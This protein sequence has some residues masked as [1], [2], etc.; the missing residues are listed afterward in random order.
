[1]PRPATGQV[2]ERDGKRGTTFA[3]RFR[4]HGERQYVTLG[5]S[6]DGWTRARADTELANTLADVRRGIWQPP[7]PAPIPDAPKDPTFHEFA[8]EWLAAKRPEVK[9]ETASHYE[10]ELTLHLLPF[11]HRHTLSQITVQEVD[12]YRQSM[13]RRG[14]LGATSINKTITRLGQILEVAVEYDLI[15]RNP[16]KG[17]RRRLKA[18]RNTRSHIDRADH[19]TALLAAAGALDAAARADRRH[20]ARRAIVATLVFGGLRIS[21][22]CALRWRDVDLAAG[23]IRV[24]EAKTEAGIRTVDVLPVLRDELIA[25]KAR[26]PRTGPGEFVFATS[27]GRRPSKDNLRGRVIAPAIDRA[28]RTL[29]QEGFAPLPDR[30]TPHGL[31]HTFASLLIALGKDPR[32]VMSQIGHTD[33][34]FTLRLYTHD[35]HREEGERDRLRALVNGTDWAP[36]GTTPVNGVAP[37][38]DATIA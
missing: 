5:S 13:V 6:T 29:E 28:S 31:R 33:P 18:P 24:G 23:R 10:A 17:K 4:A 27:A 34:A 36:T 21:E 15:A 12:R 22:L 7:R 32:Y 14:E 20:I 11:F 35:M 9:L 19:I 38:V 1:M 2:V 16:A 3:L 37:P 8:S 25:W 26:A 30:L